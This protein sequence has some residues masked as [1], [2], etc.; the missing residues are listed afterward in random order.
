MRPEDEVDMRP[1]GG[2]DVIPVDEDKEEVEGVE[3]YTS[4][5]WVGWRSDLVRK[6]GTM[7][8]SRGS[9]V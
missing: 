1:L 8:S 3:L 7:K 5:E 9:L 4:K 6:S 2:G